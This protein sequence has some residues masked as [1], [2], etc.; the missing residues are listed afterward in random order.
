MKSGGLRFGPV[1][2]D[3]IHFFLGGGG[4][5]EIVTEREDKNSTLLFTNT[6]RDVLV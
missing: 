5:L 3:E 2:N 4:E 6:P 1:L